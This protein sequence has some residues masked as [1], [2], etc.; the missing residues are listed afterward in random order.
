[1]SRT[2]PARRALLV[3]ADPA[4]SAGVGRLAAAAGVR[5]DVLADP[6]E[7]LAAWSASAVVLVGADLLESVASRAVPRRPQVQVVATAPVPDTVFR[8][9]LRVGA[10]RVLE[11][12]AAAPWLLEAL[13]DLGD[14]AADPGRSVAVIGASGGAG[15][16]VL[17]AALATVASASSD[18]LLLDLDPFGPGQ[19]L[20]VGH[21][22]AAG[23]TWSELAA[24]AGRIGARALRDAVPRRHR[25]GVLGWAA[26]RSEHLPPPGDL[27]D[28]AVAA[29]TRG[30]SWA[31]LDVPRRWDEETRSVLVGCDHT[32]LVARAG[33]GGLAAAA[34][35]ARSVAATVPASGLVVRTHRDGPPASEVAR[36]LGIDLW[37]EMRDQRRLD[38]HLALGL[39]AVHASRGPLSRTAARVLTR[40]STGPRQAAA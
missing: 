3:T 8:S 29:A 31:V 15:A 28:R 5:L 23:T 32:V 14:G 22:D 34:R 24:S 33:I 27:V 26:D 7:V 20:L 37:A 6:A 13:A 11:L 18:V 2:A 1:M 17:A 36:A 30:H 25:L 38:E 10:E 35:F 39:G 40:C 16:S 9:A 4:V 12:P 21:D 19:R